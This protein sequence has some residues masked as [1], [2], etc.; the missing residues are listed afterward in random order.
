[1]FNCICSSNFGIVISFNQLVFDILYKEKLKKD[2][3]YLANFIYQSFPGFQELFTI[4]KIQ[5]SSDLFQKQT[6][7]KGEVILK[8]GGKS[9]KLY[10][11]ESG[12]VSLYRNLPRLK[13]TDANMFKS[14]KVMDLCKGDIFGE[15]KMFFNCPNKATAK[16]TSKEVSLLI[17]SIS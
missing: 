15:D 4:R 9:N 1:M 13:F 5:K 6:V 8:E 14:C 11:I 7:S 3:E 10:L 17:I 2:G 16:V 12:Q